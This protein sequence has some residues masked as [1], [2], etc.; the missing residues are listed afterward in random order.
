[1]VSVLLSALKT[2]VP[3]VV[4]CG[5]FGSHLV[6]PSS[7]VIVPFELNLIRSS[8][9]QGGIIAKKSVIVTPPKLIPGSIVMA[10]VFQLPAVRYSVVDFEGLSSGNFILQG[11]PPGTSIQS[12]SGNG[13]TQAVINLAFDETDFDADSNNF[14]VDIQSVALVQTE[15]GFLRTDSLVIEALVEVPVATLTTYSTLQELWLDDQI[16]YIDLVQ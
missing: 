8:L 5:S 13:P 16:I 3:S 14:T 10:V 15:S 12:V 6:G 4:V 2:Q 7:S 1:M 11:A 9:E